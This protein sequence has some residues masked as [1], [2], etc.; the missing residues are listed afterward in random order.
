MLPLVSSTAAVF[1]SLAVNAA[2]YLISFHSINCQPQ[3]SGP[4][5]WKK[6][7]NKDIKLLLP[8]IKIMQSTSEALSHTLTAYFDGYCQDQG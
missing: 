5:K 8:L 7:Y 3:T 6:R 4:P 1:T 2:K